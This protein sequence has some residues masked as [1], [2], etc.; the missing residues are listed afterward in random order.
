MKIGLLI[1][2][3]LDYPDGV[4]QYV[5]TLGAW[6]THKGHEVHYITSSTYRDDLQNLHVLT[7]HRKVTFNGNCLRTPAYCKKTDIDQFFNEQRLDILHVQMPYSPLF[8]GRVIRYA[9]SNV[10]IVGTFHVAPYSPIEVIGAKALRLLYGNSLDRINQIRSV[11]ESAK[12]FA[13]SAVG[14]EAAII[15][16]MV[17]LAQFTQ[18]RAKQHQPD[19]IDIRFLG[20]LVP[21][22]G[23]RQLLRA[24]KHY[25]EHMDHNP[26]IHITIGGKGPGLKRLKQYVSAHRLDDIVTFS[27]FI[28]EAD[29]PQFFAD[30]DIIVFP[31][32]GGESF[33]IVLVEAMANGN[34]VVLAGDNP[35]YR[36]VIDD[37]SVLFDPN[38]TA[39]FSGLLAKYARSGTL[40]LKTA[41]KQK[42]RAEQFDVDAVGRRI[43]TMYDTAQADDS[44]TVEHTV[45][46]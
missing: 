26:R 4:Q 17:D 1:D 16:N 33:G 37:E 21:R 5:L 3:S 20:R 25:I 35:G 12:T 6:L 14:R 45:E 22:K 29:K 32:T 11:S 41:A 24:V 19:Y 13:H 7:K 8:A 15:P 31:S 30:A 23:C 39:K 44:K 34:S 43:L 18:V 36:K 27:G 2:D 46:A 38:D 9:P 28:D 40:R 10:A 42:K